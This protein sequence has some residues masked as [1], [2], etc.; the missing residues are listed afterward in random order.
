M[1]PVFALA[2]DHRN[3]FRTSFMRLN[4]RPTVEQTTTMIDAKGVVVEALLQA[5]PLVV[6]GTPALLIDAEYGGGFVTL[7]QASQLVIAMPVEVS[8]QAELRFEN[9]GDFAAVLERYE[10]DHAKVL[11]RYNPCGDPVMNARQRER[12]GEL[13]SWLLGR[14]PR[15]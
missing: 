11:V 14:K 8:G 3:S 13:G 7:A 1:K 5:A 10:P 9:D 2:F 6:D 4:A 15:L 12:L